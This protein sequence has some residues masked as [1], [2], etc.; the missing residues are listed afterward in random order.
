MRNPAAAFSSPPSP[1]IVA[2]RRPT[3]QACRHRSYRPRRAPRCGKDS[4]AGAVLTNRTRSSPLDYDA[5]KKGRDP[6]SSPHW[7]ARHGQPLQADHWTCA[8]VLKAHEADPGRPAP[9]FHPQGHTTE[10]AARVGTS[11][12]FV[13]RLRYSSHNVDPTRVSAC[14]IFRWRSVDSFEIAPLEPDALSAF[15][16]FGK[17]LSGRITGTRLRLCNA[18]L[19][20]AKGMPTMAYWHFP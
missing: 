10:Q 5:S 19:V 12:A 1:G 20:I 9:S 7:R 11:A 3:I 13:A 17:R 2:A 16:P 6:V 15:V 14:S 8:R 18:A 4:C